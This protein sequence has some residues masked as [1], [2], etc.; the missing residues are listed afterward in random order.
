MLCDRFTVYYFVS[1]FQL[2]S[3]K[4]NAELSWIKKKNYYKKKEIEGKK[5]KQA[6]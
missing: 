1:L 5:S 2:D 4:E 6:S 3:P